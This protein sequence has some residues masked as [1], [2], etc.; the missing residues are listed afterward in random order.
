MSLW[1]KA[2]KML[3]YVRRSILGARTTYLGRTDTLV[4][5][6]NCRLKQQIKISIEIY[7]KCLNLIHIP[8]DDWNRDLHQFSAICQYYVNI[9]WLNDNLIKIVHAERMMLNFVNLITHRSS[10]IMVRDGIIWETA[11]T[12]KIF[13]KM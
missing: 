9:L 11:T 13:A 12:L 10:C 8:I 1:S 7:M 3:S 2:K 6:L 4:S 5:E